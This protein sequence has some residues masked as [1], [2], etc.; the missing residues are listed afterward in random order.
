[1]FMCLCG[2][3]S[4]LVTCVRDDLIALRFVFLFRTRKRLQVLVLGKRG[5]L[6]TLE[7]GQ[8]KC[9][10]SI[11]CSVI[12]NPFLLYILITLNL[13]FLK[14]LKFLLFLAD[15]LAFQISNSL[16]LHLLNFRNFRI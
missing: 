10:F 4:P 9:C 6:Q 3:Q 1:M 7:R 5:T 14:I 8:N 12:S 15:C 13:I 2:A 11:L 16:Q